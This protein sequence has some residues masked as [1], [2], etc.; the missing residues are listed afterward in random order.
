MGRQANRMMKAVQG[1]P[2]PWCGKKAGYKAGTANLSDWLRAAARGAAV[3]T[4]PDQVFTYLTA[5]GMT[6]HCRKCK[7]AVGIC[8]HCDHPNRAQ[9]IV[10]SCEHCEK[11]FST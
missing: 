9:E 1:H 6:A 11:I 3:W 5:P 7:Q 10:P 2:C 4:R 8:G